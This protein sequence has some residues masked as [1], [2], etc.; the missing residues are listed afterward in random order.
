MTK[1]RVETLLQGSLPVPSLRSL[2]CCL[3]LTLNASVAWAETV[4]VD[5]NL[6]APIRSGQGTQYR[7]LHSGVRS[8]TPLE[9]IERS[10]SGYSRVRTPDG[11]EGWMVSRYLTE[12]P[13]ARQRL[14]SANR[15]LEQ[16]KE[17]VSSLQSQ[18]AEVTEE[19][20]T[21]SSSE[22]RLEARAGRL[23]QELQE[24][25]T[26]AADSLN[27]NRRNEELRNENQK[28]KNDLEVLTAE[29]ERLEA[30]KDSDFMLIGAGLVFSGVILALIV[31]ALKPTRKTDNWV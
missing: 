5:D 23:S 30:N 26:V 7:I 11:I 13:I 24:I 28:L 22:E 1:L 12:T 19:R 29:K 16:M 3:L 15:Q 20:D 27:L 25:K 21:L 14:E 9:L 4:Y 31:P 6:Y 17:T 18:L 10:E 2:L 8:G